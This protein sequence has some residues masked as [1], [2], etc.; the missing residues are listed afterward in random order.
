MFY[1]I[2]ISFWICFISLFNISILLQISNTKYSKKNTTFSMI[3]FLIALIVGNIMFYF[4]KDLETFELLNPLT[5]LIPQLIFISIFGKRNIKSTITAGINVYFAIYS[6][7]I[8]QSILNRYVL[9]E[10]EWTNYLYVILYPLI[11]LYVKFFYINLHNEIEE[12]SPKLVTCIL[13]FSSTIFILILIYNQLAKK[14]STNSLRM[15]LFSGALLGCYYFSLG[16]FYVILMSY[17]KILINEKKNELSTK[18]IEHI[19]DKVRIREKTEKEFRILRHDLRHVLISI[20]QM[21]S[22]NR[23]SEA[24]DLI[25]N[26]IQK[27][28]NTTV[29]SY[30]NDYIIDSVIDYYAGICKKNEIEYKVQI[31]GIEEETNIPHYDFAVFLSNCL[32]NAVNATKKIP[33]NRK[34]H[35]TFFNNM[36][37]LILQIKNTFNGQI[38]L[39]KNKKP[40]NRSRNHGIGTKSIDNF[41]K[42]NNL[43]IDYQITENVFTMNILFNEMN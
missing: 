13:V 29:Q 39:D 4:N 15:E 21:I 28:D 8:I 41:A 35:I 2:L 34:I 42:S 6:V 17:K 12:C 38:K 26:Y 5:I 7:Q 40:T 31:K 19:K 36:G 11:W 37:R 24:Q 32:E 16:I 22:N 33:D 30:C 43:I 14:S 25:G 23:Y 1:Q 27:V 3:I 18:E 10:A 20:S 9:T